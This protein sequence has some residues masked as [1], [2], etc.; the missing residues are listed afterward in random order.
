MSDSDTE[1]GGAVGE[2][3]TR[4]LW[5]L[6][7]ARSYLE[8]SELRAEPDSVARLIAT[9]DA[10]KRLQDAVYRCDRAIEANPPPALASQP[11]Q[12]TDW[13]AEWMKRAGEVVLLKGQLRALE[14]ERETLAKMAESW[15]H[16]GAGNRRVE[17]VD[18][19]EALCEAADM[20]L[21]AL[22]TEQAAGTCT[23]ADDDFE[24][25]MAGAGHA[26][27]CPRNSKAQDPRRSPGGDTE[28]TDP[29]PTERHSGKL[30]TGPGPQTS[31][32]VETDNPGPANANREHVSTGGAGAGTAQTPCGEE[33]GCKACG[34]TLDPSTRWLFAD[35]AELCPD[36]GPGYK[37]FPSSP[38][39]TEQDNGLCSRCDQP[40]TALNCAQHGGYKVCAAHKC[41]CHR[42]TLSPPGA[43]A[44]GEAGGMAVPSDEC[45]TC[46][47]PRESHAYWCTTKT[48]TAKPDLPGGDG[49][50]LL[51]CARLHLDD[52]DRHKGNSSVVAIT[53]LCGALDDILRHLESRALTGSEL[54]EALRWVGN[55]MH[56]DAAILKLADKLE[57]RGGR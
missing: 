20:L 51:K 45:P 4:L 1:K 24:R 46:L 28:N 27:S 34:G 3:H 54:L 40:A 21:D 38:G 53:Y 13:H 5:V 18:R 37:R 39:A 33:R 14:A 7:C 25:L 48:S 6:Q 26:D 11:V 22:R 44:Q 23:C 49:R 10:L 35:G 47:R 30:G 2:A 9:T 16:S 55:G 17:L 36:C 43:P 50:D 56:G 42:G 57:A 31:T 52:A 8:A 32:P 12:G 41:V 29:S 19:H 15:R